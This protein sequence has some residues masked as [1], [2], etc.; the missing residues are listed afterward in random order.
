MKFSLPVKGDTQDSSNRCLY[1]SCPLCGAMNHISILF[2]DAETGL[3]FQIEVVLRP[4]GN[5]TTDHMIRFSNRSYMYVRE[6]KTLILLLLDEMSFIDSLFASP[7]WW[8][9]M[10]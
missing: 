10:K 7:I 4:T 9:R 1:T 6:M 3:R 5:L 8:L 2:W